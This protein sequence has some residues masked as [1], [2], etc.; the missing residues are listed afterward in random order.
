MVIP[1]RPFLR[2][3]YDLTIGLTRPYHHRHLNSEAQA[4]LKAWSILLN[5]F[6][7]CT[8]MEVTLVSVVI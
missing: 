3:L 1:G 5:S 8:M 7:S 2:R 4:D 6:N